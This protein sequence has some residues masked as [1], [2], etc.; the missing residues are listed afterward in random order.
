MEG[1]VFADLQTRLT[2]KIVESQT[3]QNSLLSFREKKKFEPSY[4]CI[5]LDF[6]L[7]YRAEKKV[8]THLHLDW[9]TK[10]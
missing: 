5:F 9:R 10:A 4:C 3:R 1:V 7:I 8:P 2:W 6:L